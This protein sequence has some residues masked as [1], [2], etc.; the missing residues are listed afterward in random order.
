[1][2][3]IV[4]PRA[5]APA[6]KPSSSARVALA[7][8]AAL[9]LAGPPSLARAAA[10]CTHE[11]ICGLKNAE[12]F[13]R[14]P[15]SRWAIASRLAKDPAAPGGFSLVD[16]ERRTAR[17]LTPDFSGHADPRYAA[18]PG[19]LP[20]SA[21]VTHG[22]DIRRRP[23]GTAELFAVNHG[24]R[25][26]IEIFDIRMGAD[27]PQL[28]WKGCVLQAAAMSYN[29]N[30][31][32]ALPDGLVVTSF[33]TSGPG[34]LAALLAGKPGGFV[35]KW[36]PQGGWTRIA[37]SGFGG[38]NGVVASADGKTLYVND[39]SDGTL[40]RLSLD[41]KAVPI[42]IELGDFHPDNL[43]WLQDGRLLI[44]GQ[45]GKAR[46]II[47]CASHAAC[48][49]GSMIVIVDPRSQ[50]VRLRWKIPATAAFAAASTALLY[51][52]DYWASSFRGDRVVR[53]GPAPGRAGPGVAT[54]LSSPERSPTRQP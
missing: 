1:L 51:G 54:Q 6:A 10:P 39:W 29:A 9:T 26:S 42:S 11:Q 20:A 53:L 8:L 35:E 33:G 28:K 47:G 38:D 32:A 7:A 21:L 34:S 43:H 5:A 50:R 48:A 23:G 4:L 31:V 19:P 16:L 49:V 22:L 18:C 2:Q 45:V 27:G 52:S 15:G 30:A 46:D 41:G 13:V 3:K 24:G 14:I 40:R 25:E 12:D 17:V 37:G 44:A 36:T